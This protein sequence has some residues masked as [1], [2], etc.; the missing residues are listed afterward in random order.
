MDLEDPATPCGL[1]AKS[2]F[3]D[4]FKQLTYKGPTSAATQNVN[5]PLDSTKIAWATDKEFKFKNVK[6]I[7][8]PTKS[9]T[10]LAGAT[11]TYRDV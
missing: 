9:T 5:V 7:T 6:D 10:P 1:V 8:M 11:P 3:N 2:F 4:N